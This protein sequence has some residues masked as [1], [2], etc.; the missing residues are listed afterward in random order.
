MSHISKLAERIAREAADE[1]AERLSQAKVDY[2]AEQGTD[3]ERP[4]YIKWQAAVR[5]YQ[6][7]TFS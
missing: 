7:A 2:L 1:A 4:A 5:D 3:G 6:D